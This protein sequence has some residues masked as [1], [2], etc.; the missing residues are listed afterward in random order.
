MVQSRLIYRISE[1]ILSRFFSNLADSLPQILPC[2]KYEFVIKNTEEY[3][4]QIWNE[5]E[6]FVLHN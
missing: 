4:K 5:C 3:Y 1:N 2:P 6:D